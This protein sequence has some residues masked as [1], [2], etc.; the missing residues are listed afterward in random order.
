MRYKVRISLPPSEGYVADILSPEIGRDS[1]RAKVSL[2]SGMDGVHIYIEAMDNAAL[3]SALGG[4]SR[5]MILISRFMG[6]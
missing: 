5:L 4:I 2:S 1:P 3:R 6:D